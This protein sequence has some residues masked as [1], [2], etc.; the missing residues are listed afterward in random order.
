MA[1][2]NY[3]SAETI[4]AMLVLVTENSIDRNWVNF[5]IGAAEAMRKSCVFQSVQD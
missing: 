1:A 3:Q 4:K 5:E 2:N